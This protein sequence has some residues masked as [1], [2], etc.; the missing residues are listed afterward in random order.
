[1]SVTRRGFF[2]S[3]L[4]LF[5]CGE[6]AKEVKTEKKADYSKF[7]MPSRVICFGAGEA[8]ASSEEIDRIKR[9][10]EALYTGPRNCNPLVIPNPGCQIKSN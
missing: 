2:G 6:V 5:G 10:L 9:E 7:V 1:M 3:L 8:D 4:G